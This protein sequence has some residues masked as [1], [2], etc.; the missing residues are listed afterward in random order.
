MKIRIVDKQVKHILNLT[1][2]ELMLLLR[3]Q[4]LQNRRV[5][6]Q[7]VS[8]VLIVCGD[9]KYEV[10]IKSVDQL[11]SV[12]RVPYSDPSRIDEMEEFFDES[13][14]PY[15]VGRDR[16]IRRVPYLDG[17]FTDKP[18]RRKTRKKVDPTLKIPSFMMEVE[19]SAKLFGSLM[20]VESP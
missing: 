8:P 5:P 19:L 13:R 12:G 2:E 3:L 4:P 7:I 1:S 15:E 10:T 16:S 11:E 9:D 20:K 14:V 17:S 18:V 6:F